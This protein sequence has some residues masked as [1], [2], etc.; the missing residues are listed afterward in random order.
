MSKGLQRSLR[1]G[2]AALT[3]P[4]NLRI[5]IN[6]TIAIADPGGAV[7]FASGVIGDFPSGN[8]LFHGAVLYLT[9]TKG[10]ADII[11][12]FTGNFSLGTT[13]TADATLGTTDANLIPST[14]FQTGSGGVSS[15][16]R[17]VST[18]TETGAILDNTDGSLEMN[19]N[20]TI[21]DASISADSSVAFVGALF[22]SYTVLGDD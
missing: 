12:A 19:L 5:P 17:G 4:L 3:G 2:R 16:N 14:A 1:R 10:D 21:A 22:I 11:D 13:A 15:G 8:I 6:T 20:F 7:A 9:A 18:T